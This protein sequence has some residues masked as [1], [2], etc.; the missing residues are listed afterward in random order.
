LKKDVPN[1][2]FQ[3]QDVKINPGRLGYSASGI[4]KCTKVR[5]LKPFVFSTE[6]VEAA[7]L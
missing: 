5:L 3:K 1:L 7:V 4:R 6:P 2:K